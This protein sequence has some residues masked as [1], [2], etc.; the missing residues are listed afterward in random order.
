MDTLDNINS[1]EGILCYKSTL[2]NIPLRGA[3]QLLSI[4]NMDCNMC[5]IDLTPEEMKKSGILK[6]A[7]EWLPIGESMKD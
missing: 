3:F 5:Y 2:T 7:D 6:T 4:Y 1:I